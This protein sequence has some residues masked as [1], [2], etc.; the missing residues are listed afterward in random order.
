MGADRSGGDENCAD[1]AEHDPELFR[2][3]YKK[4]PV[5]FL[6]SYRATQLRVA[7]L[8]EKFQGVQINIRVE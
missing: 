4:D 3:Y 5:Q 7:R 2:A 1:M 6:Q 8:R